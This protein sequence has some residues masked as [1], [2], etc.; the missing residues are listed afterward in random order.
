MGKMSV[1]I[2]NGK[3]KRKAAGKT[4]EQRLL[5]ELKATCKTSGES[6]ISLQNR[7]YFFA[8][9]RRARASARRARSVRR[10]TGGARKNF[11]FRAPPVVSRTSRSPRAYP[12]SPEKR[13]KI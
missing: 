13:K 6:E 8:F 2:L 10:A 1:F 11:C 4:L 7:R 3:M 12:R 5:M 9:F